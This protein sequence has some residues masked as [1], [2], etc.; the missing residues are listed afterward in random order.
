MLKL[1][2]FNYLLT[3]SRRRISASDIVSAFFFSVRSNAPWWRYIMDGGVGAGE[4]PLQRGESWAME[5]VSCTEHSGN[6][7][8]NATLRTPTRHLYSAS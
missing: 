3:R 8:F 7:L 5:H 2:A 1:M 6:L 4:R